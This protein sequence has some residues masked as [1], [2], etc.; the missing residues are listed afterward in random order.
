MQAGYIVGLLF[1]ILLFFAAY[2]SVLGMLEPIVSYLEE[3]RGYSRPMMTVLVGLFSWVLGIAAALSFNI[4]ADVRLLGAIPYFA[5]KTIFDLLDFFIANFLLPLNALLIA[6]FAGWMMTH[7]SL[8]EELGV[9]S[10]ALSRFLR[11]VLRYVAPVLI[12]TIF[13]QSL[14]GA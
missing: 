10:I 4:W 2:S 9:T 14:V 3:H 1:F 7:E 5:D 6:V 8:L 13:Y 11:I 12:G